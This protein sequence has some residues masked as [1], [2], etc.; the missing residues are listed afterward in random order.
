MIPLSRDSTRVTLGFCFP[1]ET[2]ALPLFD[3]VFE[4]WVYN[5]PACRLPCSLLPSSPACLSSRLN[6]EE[7]LRRQRYCLSD[8]HSSHFGRCFNGKEVNVPAEIDS[9]LGMS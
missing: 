1:K 3:Q 8:A 7:L 2:I 5:A 9:E 4:R 6:L